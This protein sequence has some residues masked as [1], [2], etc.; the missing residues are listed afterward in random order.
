MSETPE[1]YQT[2]AY[3]AIME[4]REVTLKANPLASQVGGSHYKDM[5]IQPIEYI[6]AND[7]L[8]LE[9]CIV[10]YASRHRN[11]NKAEDIRK[12]IQCAELI[13]ARDYS[14]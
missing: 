5:A 13:L 2:S 14:E 10:K 1:I 8:F 6:N 7:M 11:K 9:G 12:I 3:K 4:M